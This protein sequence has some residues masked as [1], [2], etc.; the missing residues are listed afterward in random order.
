MG[1]VA[2]EDLGVTLEVLVASSGTTTTRLRV[3]P[4]LPSRHT[5]SSAS[6]SQSFP[7]CDYVVSMAN[8]HLRVGETEE[9]FERTLASKI[10]RRHQSLLASETTATLKIANS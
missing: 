7:E 10:A 8:G 6:A 9:A 4:H 2:S 5:L 3:G 1:V